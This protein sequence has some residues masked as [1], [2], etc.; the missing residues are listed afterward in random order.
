MV[1]AGAAEVDGGDGLA[2]AGRRLD[3]AET[4]ID[5][6]RRADDQHRVGV[7]EMAH[8]RLDPVA[9]HVLAEEH[10]VGLEDAAAMRAG[11]DGEGRKIDAVE[12]GVAV[13]RDD[14][15]EREPSRVQSFESFLQRLP[16]R[17]DVA[18]HA[19]DTVEAAV[20]VDHRFAASGLMQPVDVLGQQDL[21]LADRL[22]PRQRAVRVIRPG[23]ADAPPADQAARPV[24][25]PRRLLSHEGLI[26]DWR[27]ALPG[28]VGVTIIGNARVHAASGA[29]QNE[30]A[31]MVV[32]KFL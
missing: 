22:E 13:R 23:A 8:R 25:P 1:G 21:A 4:R 29:G 32:D 26:G 9:R 12:I 15:L 17:D 30:E 6:Q 5:H 24:A 7:F 3:E 28:A 16:R 10:D 2:G 11:G 14:G 27:R 31:A 18:A 19:A 20:Q